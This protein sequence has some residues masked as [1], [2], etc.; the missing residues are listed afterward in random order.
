MK[1]KFSVCHLALMSVLLKARSD[2]GMFKTEASQRLHRAHN[3]ISEVEYGRRGLSVCEFIDYAIVLGVDPM[4]MF[5]RLLA[6]RAMFSADASAH[7]AA[8]KKPKKSA[9]AGRKSRPRKS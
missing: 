6:E 8:N 4:E 1:H 5:G 3:F 9:K 2:A 7:S